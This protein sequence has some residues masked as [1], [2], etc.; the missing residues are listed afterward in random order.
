LLQ[1]DNRVET[2]LRIGDVVGNSEE[3]R[4]VLEEADGGVEGAR[5]TS[6]LVFG[7]II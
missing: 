6:S 5:Y 3:S 1:N 7:G 2:V 4:D